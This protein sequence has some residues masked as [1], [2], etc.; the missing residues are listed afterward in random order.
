MHAGDEKLYKVS[1]QKRE[2][3]RLLRD[4]GVDERMLLKWILNKQCEG[5]NSTQL[6]LNKV[7]WLIFV[8]TV[9]KLGCHK[10]RRF[11]DQL[12]EC[13]VSKKDSA[14]WSIFLLISQVLTVFSV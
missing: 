3:R 7:Q 8:N 11:L 9:M 14:L 10:S 2:R 6:S 13:L 12:C 5:I 1:V 4:L